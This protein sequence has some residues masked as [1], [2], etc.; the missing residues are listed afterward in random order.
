MVSTENGPTQRFYNVTPLITP[1]NNGAPSNSNTQ[2]NITYYS[3]LA[4]YD[5]NEY[6]ATSNGG[7]QLAVPT[8]P[9]VLVTYFKM[10][11]FYAVGGVYETWIVTGNASLTPPSG[12]TLTNISITASWQS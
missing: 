4:Q 7:S 9:P 11:G 8:N 10:R 1:V 5:N 12:H 2:T 6:G 3:P